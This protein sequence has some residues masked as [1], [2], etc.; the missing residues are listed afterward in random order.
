MSNVVIEK[1][2]EKLN[3]FDKKYNELLV[4][5]DYLEY[6]DFYQEVGK[7]FFSMLDFK[8][9]FIFSYFEY[10]KYKSLYY[11]EL[12][13]Y[14][15]IKTS[16]DIHNKHLLERD[17]QR[18]KTVCGKI[19]GKE[20]DN[21]QI[22]AIVRRNN[23]QLVIAGAGSGKTTTIV[24][25]VKYLL[26][27]EQVKPEDILLLSF[28]NASASEMKERIKKETNTDLD[29]FT[30]HK[31]GL[32]IIKKSINDN[33]KIFDKDLYGVV[34]KILNENMKDQYYS[35]KLIYFIATA[36]YNVKDEFDFKTENEYKEY[37]K[38]NKITTLKG[39]IVKSY[40][41]LEIANYLYS[42]NIDYEYEKEY[43]YNTMNS[44]YSQYIPDFYLPK[45]DIYI[46]YFGI[47]ENNEVAPYFKSRDGV[48]ASDA[49]NESIKWKRKTHKKNKTNLI[50]TFYYEKKKDKLIENLEKNLKKYNVDIVPKNT[51]EMWQ[52]I[53][54]NNSGILN[55]ICR[56]FET[57]INLIKSND[58]SFDYLYSLDSVKLFK[59]NTVLLDLIRPIYNEYQNALKSKN[60]IDFNDMINMATVYIN[61]NK[62]IHNYKYIIVD[63]YQDISKSRYKLLLSMRM[64]NKF[65][66]FCVGDD[67]QSIYRFNGSDIDLIINFENYWGRS[68]IS[69]IEKTYRFTSM[70]ATLSGNF[71]MKNPKQYKKNINAKLSEDYAVGFVNAYTDKFCVDFLGERLNNFEKNSTVFFLGRYSF[72]INIFKDNKDYILKYN[73]SEQM[74]DIVYV[75]RRDLKIKFLTIHKSK[76]LQADYVV[77]LN[78]KDTGMG[79]PSKINDLPLVHI[80]LSGTSDNYQYA[81]ERR[82]FYVA[83]TRSKKKTILLTVDNNKSCFIQEIEKEYNTMIKYDKELKSSIYR[84]P[85][86]GGKLIPK[87]GP[88]SR[89]LG[90]SNYPKCKFTK[91]Y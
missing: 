1:E 25:K 4:S 47:D 66:L 68:Y 55:E 36:R 42:N 84:C 32:E 26:K 74:T 50:E 54:K 34:K 7:S 90:C 67:W 82:L 43:K 23:N 24:G 78:N 51:E 18:F 85:E 72:D 80:L 39:E 48:S 46:E 14:N 83:L 75:K 49:Y 13:K 16:I 60:M 70:M 17:I 61:D 3:I 71:I 57:I 8:F 28:T 20:L 11:K 81:E 2:V 53:N 64:Q 40:G 58:Y 9:K 76:G 12:S 65:K 30:F 63:E 52:I 86:C 27:C 87:K 38:S 56:T 37:L 73:P 41:E 31:L 79:F 15:S 5:S 33:I 6:D 69:F 62:F 91:K 10:K 22:D 29:V 45:Y 89:F 59:I 19:E 77:I 44:E 88:Y 35:D 21:Q